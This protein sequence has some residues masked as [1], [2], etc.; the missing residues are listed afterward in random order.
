M[1]GGSATIIGNVGDNFGAG[2]TGGYAFIYSKQKNLFNLINK[3]SISLYQIIETEWQNVLLDNLKNFHKETGSKKAE[4]I[5]QN[6][7][8]EVLNFIHV[9]PDE[10]VNKL[11][12]PIK[13]N[14]KIA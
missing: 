11:K 1:T 7:K 3:E 8:T 10:V 5:I 6:F 12:Y 13:N 4:F 14:L 2:M 9:V